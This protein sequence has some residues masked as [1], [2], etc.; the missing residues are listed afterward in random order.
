VNMSKDKLVEIFLEKLGDP[1]DPQK[2]NQYLNFCR[3]KR[4]VIVGSYVESHHVLPRGV[5]PEY[6]NF[7]E[8]EWNKVVLSYPMHV[9]AHSL[10]AAAYPIAAFCNPL[11]FMPLH[12]EKIKEDVHTALSERTRKFW[13]EFKKNIPKYNEWRKKKSEMMTL[14]MKSGTD[15]QKKCS[16]YVQ[17][18]FSKEEERKKVSYQFRSLWKD[19]DY[20]IDLISKMLSSWTKVR[21]EKNG[22]EAAKRWADPAYHQKMV[23]IMSDINKG[24]EKRKDAGEKLKALWKDP[25]YREHVLLARRGGK[26][27][28]T[29]NTLKEK[30]KDPIWR[31]FMLDAR[32]KNIPSIPWNK[33]M[34]GLYKRKVKNETN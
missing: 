19:E 4:K 12:T 15:Y 27:P 32:K 26:K 10:L 22:V 13:I 8:Y 9:E 24:I 1:F 23:G 29:S 17:K 20:R 14:K 34:K 28:T 30:W 11:R 3:K 25:V 18:R 6:K 33:G 21:R 5:F 16:Q 7:N 2:L 31:Q